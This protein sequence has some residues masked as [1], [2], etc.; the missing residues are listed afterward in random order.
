MTC[1]FKAKLT[2]RAA[3]AVAVSYLLL[4]RHVTDVHGS[5]VQ[6]GHH[7]NGRHCLLLSVGYNRQV[8]RPLLKVLQST[9]T[10]HQA[11]S[12]FSHSFHLL[13]SK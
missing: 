8:L 3:E 9:T 6:L 12:V 2:A 11:Y 5:L 4:L 13:L 1:L 7:Q 10:N